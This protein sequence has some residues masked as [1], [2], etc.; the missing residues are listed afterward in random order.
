MRLTAMALQTIDAVLCGKIR[1]RAPRE[2][3]STA[4][5]TI[6]RHRH[7]MLGSVAM[8]AQKFGNILPM[9]HRQIAMHH[10]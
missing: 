3:I 7:C 1:Q 5:T 6:A 4:A 2:Q 9:Q 10:Q 8:S